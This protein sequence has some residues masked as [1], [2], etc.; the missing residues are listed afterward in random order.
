MGHTYH[1]GNWVLS[2]VA[3]QNI[4]L[5]K[6]PQFKVIV[7]ACYIKIPRKE[8]TGVWLSDR[9]QRD[10]RTCL[11]GD[12]LVCTRERKSQLSLEEP[13]SLHLVFSMNRR[14]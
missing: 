5:L 2:L 4:T 9:A 7:R 8:S 13:H 11:R 6:V 14:I 10:L 12:F 3:P 1:E